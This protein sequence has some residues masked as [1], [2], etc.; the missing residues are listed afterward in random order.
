L[1]AA[2]ADVTDETRANDDSPHTDAPFSAEAASES[3][4]IGEGEHSSSEHSDSIAA[5]E[6]EQQQAEAPIALTA[7]PKDGAAHTPRPDW[8]DQ[9]PTRIGNIRR[10]VVATEEYATEDECLQARDIYLLLKTYEHLQRLMGLP[11]NDTML[12]SIYYGRYAVQFDGTEVT[13][14][15]ADQ[16]W[17]FDGGELVW[18]DHRL[19]RLQAMG[20]GPDYVQREVAKKEH[21][22]TVERSFGPMKKLYTL[23]EFSPTVD[24]EL[25]QRWTEYERKSR[26]ATVSAG[27]G[28]V[29]GLLGLIYGLLR[30]DT[31]TKGYYT[32]R[33]FLGVPAA[34]IGLA[35]LLA[36]RVFG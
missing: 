15:N 2:E 29:V 8:I 12:P 23:I 26:L 17:R 36:M 11:Y 22:E 9:L 19:G 1:I 18:D 30:V 16:T 14:D 21:L 35:T 3:S 4:R 33:L 20:I 34:I 10:E 31:W 25:R 27:T 7:A 28:G 6:Y 13:R 32:K 24:S 5:G